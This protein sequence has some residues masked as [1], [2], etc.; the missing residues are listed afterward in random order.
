MNIGE[1]L[2]LVLIVFIWIFPFLLVFQSNKISGK[3][4][5][6]WLLSLIFISWFAWVLYLLFAPIGESKERSI[7]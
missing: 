6:M 5:V 3:E 1:V 4:K 2:F 7:K